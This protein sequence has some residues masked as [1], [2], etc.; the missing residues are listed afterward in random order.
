LDSWTSNNDISILAVI[1][2]WLTE[3]FV[4]KERVLEFIEIDRAKS[5][6]NIAGI[7]IELLQELNINDKV[8]SITSNNASNNE[9][10]VNIVESSLIEQFQWIENPLKALRFHS[11]DSFIRCITY[12]L[13]RIV[14][15]ILTTLNSRDRATTT[16]S[17]ELVSDRQ[18][19]ST[20]DSPLACLRV[21]VI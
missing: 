17:I 8:I 1:G 7:V 13:N 12:I 18:Y 3:D 4:Y 20:S 5:R 9:T 16:N 15:L 21:L 2:H 19:L 10:L 11:Q 6:E 14:K